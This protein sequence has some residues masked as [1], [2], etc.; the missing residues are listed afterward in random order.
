MSGRNDSLDFGQRSNDSQ[1]STLDV[2]REELE[3]KHPAPRPSAAAL[4]P[5]ELL[6]FRVSIVDSEADLERVQDLR[7]AAYGHHLPALAAT[8]GKP[9]P[10]D[11]WPDVTIFFA[12]D[13]ITR[14]VVGSA[15]L[16]CN[17]SQPLQIERSI[18]LPPRLVGKLLAEV[19]RMSVIPGYAHPVKLALVKAIHLYCIAMQIGGIVC[20]S[21]PSLIRQYLNLGFEDLYGDNRLAPLAHTGGLEHRVLFRDTVTSEAF[22]RERRHPDYDFVFRTYHPDIEV[23]D[24]VTRVPGPLRQTPEERRYSRA[25]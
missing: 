17:R 16:Q 7:Q 14:R 1:F 12:E 5:G 10:V 23:F 20:G 22:N 11:R 3:T 19:T 8:V 21:R 6:A 24:A 4:A 2:P 15:R 9:D 25:A 13:K 18:A